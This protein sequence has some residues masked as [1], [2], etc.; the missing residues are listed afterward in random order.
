MIILTKIEL[1]ANSGIT[2]D[3]FFTS[4]IIQ[5]P[6]NIVKGERGCFYILCITA[7]QSR[8]QHRF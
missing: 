3:L 1:N 7:L 2:I 6:Q 4:T 8:Q 5:L